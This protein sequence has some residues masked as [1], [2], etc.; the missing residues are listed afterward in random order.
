ML[1]DSHCHLN[2][3][4]FEGKIDQFVARAIENDVKYMQTICTKLGEFPD[5]LKI[6][7]DYKNIW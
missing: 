4:D 5:I 6:A 7:N 3:P 1:V 2:F